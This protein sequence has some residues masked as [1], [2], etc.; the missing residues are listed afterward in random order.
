MEIEIPYN[1]PKVAE[2]VILL[3]GSTLEEKDR[4]Q[5]FNGMFWGIT[6]EQYEHT[7]HYLSCLQRPLILSHSEN[8][9]QDFRTISVRGCMT[10][11]RTMLSCSREGR[12][13][14]YLSKRSEGW[15]KVLSVKTWGS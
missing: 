13:K 7:K 14:N 2:L 10:I 5:I 15:L 4:N 1:H 3:K 6:N 12:L 9:D 8:S 11:L